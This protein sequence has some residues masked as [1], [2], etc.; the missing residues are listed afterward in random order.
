M[1]GEAV[2]APPTGLRTGVLKPQDFFFFFFHGEFSV[3]F[4][5]H[6]IPYLGGVGG[7]NYS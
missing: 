5:S 7:N 4:P 3:Y 6:L 1:G 2:A